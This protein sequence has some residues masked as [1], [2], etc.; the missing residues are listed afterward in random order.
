MLDELAVLGSPQDRILYE[1]E[2]A[3]GLTRRQLLSKQQSSTFVAARRTAA[4]R[5]RASGYSLREIGRILHR[6]RS[7]IQYL[8]RRNGWRAA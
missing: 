7:G 2:Q 5:L 3:V 4:K 1:V 6:D 8:L